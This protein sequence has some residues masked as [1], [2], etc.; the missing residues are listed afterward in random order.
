M[1]LTELSKKPVKIVIENN[2]SLDMIFPNDKRA[3]LIEKIINKLGDDA[4][5]ENFLLV[6]VNEEHEIQAVMTSND[7]TK[8]IEVL[9]S[10][11]AITK[12]SELNLEKEFPVKFKINS[13]DLI[14]NLLDMFTREQTDIII[15][16]DEENKYLGKVKRSG[17]YE[18]FKIML[19]SEL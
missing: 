2:I 11:P 4:G 12:V 7:V 16:V 9:S 1:K 19:K 15:V 5:S 6:Y 13:S 17:L 3:S 8:L 18:W 14:E 10:N